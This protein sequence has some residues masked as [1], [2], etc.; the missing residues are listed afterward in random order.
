MI[1]KCDK[2]TNFSLYT[3]PSTSRAMTK[4]AHNYDKSDRSWKF[5]NINFSLIIGK[6][7][8]TE[9]I[10]VK[11][12]N[13]LKNSCVMLKG[14]IL[15]T[16]HSCNE[17]WLIEGCLHINSLLP[18]HQSQFVTYKLWWILYI[19]VLHNN[20]SNFSPEEWWVGW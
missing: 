3:Q 17:L 9:L 19:L 6:C 11:L 5:L 2:S 20:Y 14:T 15:T 13:F 16:I 4:V 18:F 7:A 8:T 10:F 1:L 12:R